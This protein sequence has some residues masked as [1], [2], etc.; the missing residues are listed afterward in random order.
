MK[1]QLFVKP[2]NWLLITCLTIGTMA[3]GAVATY[4]IWRYQSLKTTSP[5]VASTTPR[6]LKAVAALGYVE[7]AGETIKISA[8]AFME[9]SRLDKLLVKQGEQVE[10]G[11]VLAILDSRDRLQAAL[12]QAQDQVRIAQSLLTQVKAGAK[13]GDI[14]AQNARFEGTRSELEGQ[15]T[16][17]RA[18]IASLTAQLQGEKMAQY[19]TIER[20][21]AEFHNAQKDCQRYHT[22]YQEGAVSEQERDRFCLMAQTSQESV[23]EANA[24]LNRIVTTLTAKIDEAEA[25]LQRTVATLDQ[26]IKENQATLDAVAEVRPVDVE[27]AQSQL[28]AAK[29]AVQKA[30]ADLDLAFVKAPKAGQILKIYTWPGEL[31]GDKGILDLGQTSQMYVTSEV[32]ETDVSRVKL[33]QRAK[34]TTDGLIGELRGTVAEIGLQIGKKDV[35]GTDPVADA[36][37]RVVEV[38]IRLDPSSS[39]KVANLTNLQ[40]NVVIDTNKTNL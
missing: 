27:V 20:I 31:I 21:K 22:L 17:Q 33:G 10:A 11:Q 6:K 25:N 1:S 13:Q 18:T 24:N 19:A 38:K 3:S 26:K 4:S 16:T 2:T 14:I 39:K 35:L 5:A 8:A 23:R 32:Y 36:D 12:K 34:I 9:G 30:K 28:I 7:P 15:I 40:V 29:S 37:A